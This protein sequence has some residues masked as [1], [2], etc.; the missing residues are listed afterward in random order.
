MLKLTVLV[1]NNTII[2]RYF[3]AEPGLSF[4]IEH[5]TEKYLFDTGY[6][7]IFVRNATKMGINLLDVDGV[8]LSHGHNDHTWGLAE[9][10]KL[11]SEAQAEGSRSKTPALIA[12]PEAF[13]D[14]N[15][16]GLAI[17]TMISSEQ[18]R[19]TFSLKLS[20]EPVWITPRLVFLGEVERKN[21][22]EIENSIGKILRGHTWEDDFI[23]DDSALVY[24]ADNGLVIM[25][26]CSHAGI[27]NIIEYAKKVCNQESVYD[28]I[29]G[30]HLLNPS[31]NKLSN[32]ADYFKSCRPHAVYACHCTDLQSKIRLAQVSN[33]QEVGVGLV[34]EYK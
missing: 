1:D 33:L 5:D 24:M 17:G 22:F 6:S 27:C 11:Y 13:L 18:L 4:F 12:H 21:S 7:G 26:G 9:L 31:Q 29:G 34:L 30:F 25:T 8:V 15:I 20:K 19:K 14:R 28:I 23:L 16:D 2:D 10:V 3:Y 32:T